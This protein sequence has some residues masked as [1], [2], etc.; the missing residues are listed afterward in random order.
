MIN[1]FRIFLLCMIVCF[2]PV[3]FFSQTP[4]P[5]NKVTISNSALEAI[6]AERVKK[7]VD[8]AVAVAVKDTELKYTSIISE[9]KLKIIETEVERDFANVDKIAYRTKYE[10][11]QVMFDVYKRDTAGNYFLIGGISV[12]AGFGGGLITYSLVVNK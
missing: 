9:L 8:D 10:N 11:I 6:I 7:A 5:N 12:L 2:M 3:S 4:P 1:Y